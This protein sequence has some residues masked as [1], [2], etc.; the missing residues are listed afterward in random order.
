MK[1]PRPRSKSY[2]SVHG[3]L[4]E[5]CRAGGRVALVEF[6]RR[7]RVRRQREVSCGTIKFEKTSG[8]PVKVKIVESDRPPPFE[9]GF[10]GLRRRRRR[11]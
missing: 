7:G 2:V 5:A 10:D 8:P 1:R 11:V 6:D 3:S 9:E 4:R